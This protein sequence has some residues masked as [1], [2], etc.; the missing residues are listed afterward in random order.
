LVLASG[1]TIQPSPPHGVD[2]NL[3]R[4]VAEE[5]PV[6]KDPN[7]IREMLNHAKNDMTF[8]TITFEVTPIQAQVIVYV[9][10][11]FNDAITVMLRHP[12]D[13]Q[14]DRRPTTNLADVMG[15]EP[16]LVR[17]KKMPPPRAIPRP[18]FY[19]LRG[20]QQIGVGENY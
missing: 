20:N 5:Y 6:Y 7:E 16:Y 14:L 12:D 4:A 18:R 2:Q 1:R 17:G 13:R 15:P 9:L 8:Q 10:T 19:D 11:V 3:I